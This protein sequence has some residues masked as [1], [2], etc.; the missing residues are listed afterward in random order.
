MNPEEKIQL[1]RKMQAKLSW[2]R[3]EALRERERL[4][5]FI[6]DNFG[7]Y[8]PKTRTRYKKLLKDAYETKDVAILRRDKN[9]S[10]Q[11]RNHRMIIAGK[12]TGREADTIATIEE[13]YSQLVKA[14]YSLGDMGI[15]VAALFQNGGKW[16]T[17]TMGH[18]FTKHRICPVWNYR[19]SQLIRSIYRRYLIDNPDIIEK[20]HPVH[21]VLTVPH[22]G[23]LYKNKKFYAAEILADFRELRRRKDWKEMVYAGEYGIETTVSESGNGFHIHIHSLVFLHNN[24]VEPFREA[25]SKHWKSLTGATETRVKTLYFNKKDESG[26]YIMELDNKNGE[27]KLVKK[28]FFVDAEKRLINKMKISPEEKKEKI[29]EVYLRGILEGIKYHFKGSEVF[30]DIDELNNILENTAGKRLYSRFGKFYKEPA[31]NF[32]R[33][34]DNEGE[35]ILESTEKA[36]NPFNGSE[37][38]STA[39]QLVT[40]Y[41]QKQKRQPQGAPEPFA[42]INNRD[43]SFYTPVPENMTVKAIL[44][45]I[46]EDKFSF[47]KTKYNTVPEKEKQS[48]IFREF[49][50]RK[51]RDMESETELVFYN[52]RELKDV[53]F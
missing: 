53:P 43:N 3:G 16:D 42:L 25:I 22:K 32:N 52:P 4:N 51:R 39:A 13:H 50:R 6:N 35:V 24:H 18:L 28:E 15:S 45:R 12:G 23:G 20:Y 9:N 27:K 49:A 36:L 11:A 19:K 2:K 8:L 40:F 26:R 37:I 29:L 1:N 38:E 14:Y 44:K 10:R 34:L 46:V 33:L 30:E 48:E 21:M 47:D 5:D 7:I 17:Y 41:P 31:L